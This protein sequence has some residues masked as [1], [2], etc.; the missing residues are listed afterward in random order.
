[1]RRKQLLAISYPARISADEDGFCVTFRDVP[2]A[3]TEGDNREQALANAQDALS[4][5]LATHLEYG[6]EI[7]E[8]SEPK[9]GEVMV[10][11]AADVAGVLALRLGR[12]SASLSKAALAR[13]LGVSRQSYGQL[14][15]FGTNL[16]LRKLD[17]VTTAMGYAVELRLVRRP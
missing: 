16:S 14:E 3:I 2:A 1:V 15:S 7:P 5:A 12:L 6:D 9:R 13:M 8:P 11:V 17:E 4:G 10:L